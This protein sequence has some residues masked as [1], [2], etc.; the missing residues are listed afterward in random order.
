ML[1]C[2]RLSFFCL[3][4][5][6]CFSGCGGSLPDEIVTEEVP[7]EELEEMEKNAAIEPRARLL[8]LS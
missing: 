2:L 8:S 4:L 7:E 3:A 5:P 6:F 1:Q